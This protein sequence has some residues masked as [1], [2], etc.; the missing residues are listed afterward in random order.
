MNRNLRNAVLLGSVLIMAAAATA[1]AQT[2]RRPGAPAPARPSPT[3][4]VDPWADLKAEELA[5][6]IDFVATVPEA[7]GLYITSSEQMMI[8][9]VRMLAPEQARAAVLPLFNSIARQLYTGR[10][11]GAEVASDIRF[12]KKP[13][14]DE[15][16][17]AAVSQSAGSNETL[18]NLLAPQIID[19]RMLVRLLNRLKEIQR[20]DAWAPIGPFKKPLKMGVTDPAVVKLKA[21]LALLG[22]KIDNMDARFDEQTGAGVADVQRQLKMKPDVIVSPGGATQN[23]LETPLTERIEQVRADL[24]KIRWLPQDPTGRYIFVNLAFSNFLLIDRSQANPVVFNFKT[25]NGRVERKT[26]SMQD[27]IYQVILNPYWTVPPTVFIKDKVEIIRNLGYWEVENYFAQN[28]FIVVSENFRT[29]Y[30]PSQID[31]QNIT[32]SSGN[33]FYIR[34]MPNY[35]NALGVVKFA[36]TNGEA[37]YLHDTGERDLFNEENRLRSSGCVRVEKPIDLAEYILAGTKWD[38]FTIENHVVRPGEVL[39]KETPVE[40]K[41]TIPVYMLPI[42]SHYGSDQVIRFTTDVYGHNAAIRANTQFSV[43]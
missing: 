40:V 21:R 23:Y 27:K 37:I 8:N 32:S 19:Y 35:Y 3:P 5:Q 33:G 38:R 30:S 31:W 6:M 26:P 10:L 43:F 36:L 7:H 16:I 18:V 4:R 11:S 25:I 41:N 1:R 29:R 24:E 20:T 15:K 28:N 2:A 22:F 42:T 13:L 17:R 39:D 9:Q 14:A 12:T 34:Q